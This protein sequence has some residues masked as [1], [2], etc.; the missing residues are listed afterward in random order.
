MSGGAEGVTRRQDGSYSSETLHALEGRLVELQDRLNGI[1]VRRTRYVEEIEK[2]DRQGEEAET[3][4]ALV[5]RDLDALRLMYA[6]WYPEL[7]FVEAAET[8]APES[9]PF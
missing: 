8:P 2:C 1:A 6:R 5:Q 7:E 3:E 4:R 9:P